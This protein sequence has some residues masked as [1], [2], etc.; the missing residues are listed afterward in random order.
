M[1]VDFAEMHKVAIAADSRRKEVRVAYLD[2]A[3]VLELLT[4]PKLF[5]FKG[6]ELCLLQQGLRKLCVLAFHAC[7]R[8]A[9]ANRSPLQPDC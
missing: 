8:P 2:I 6:D 3:V 4:N 5:E 1:H 7:L 9:R